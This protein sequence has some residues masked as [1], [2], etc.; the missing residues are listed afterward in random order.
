MTRKRTSAPVG[1]TID[2]EPTKPRLAW[3]GMDARQEVK[4]VQTHVVE[5]VDPSHMTVYEGTRLLYANP[6]RD[7]APTSEEK[8]RR[9]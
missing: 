7:M 6:P 5:Y 4:A 9:R 1:I 3:Q 2:V 8:K